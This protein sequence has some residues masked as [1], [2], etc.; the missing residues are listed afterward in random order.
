MNLLLDQNK[1]E[2]LF[3][4]RVACYRKDFL[5]FA[6]GG[7][8]L[9]VLVAAGLGFVL[10]VEIVGAIAFVPAPDQ[11]ML[12]YALLFLCLGYLQYRKQ[13]SNKTVLESSAAGAFT[14]FPFLFLHELLEGRHGYTSGRP[15]RIAFEIMAEGG[16]VISKE[17]LRQKSTTEPEATQR[18]IYLL[19]QMRFL[20]FRRLEGGKLLRTLEW[21]EFLEQAGEKVEFQKEF[22]ENQTP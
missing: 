4:E 18:A 12:L 9:S 2:T 8:L 13:I 7:A 22:L 15:V 1:L 3:N 5:F 6:A 21:Q 11:F 16:D 17:F 19:V 10:Y 14:S 20:I